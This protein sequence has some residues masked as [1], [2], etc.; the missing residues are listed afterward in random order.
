MLFLAGS[1]L[2]STS[3]TIGFK[4]CQGLRIDTFQAIIANYFVCIVTGFLFGSS[5]PF[6][7]NA[8]GSPWFPIAILLG[9][10]FITFFNLTAF[11]VKRLGVAVAGVATK[12]SLVIPFIFSL[13]YYGEHAG[14]QKWTGVAL[15]LFSVV[16][17][18]YD[19]RSNTLQK[20][21]L[22]LWILPF[23]LFL[24]TGFQDTMIKFAEHG[25]LMPAE[26]DAFLITC[27][28]VAFTIGL[29]LM[30]YLM[31]RRRLNFQ[32]KAMIAGICIGIPNY[33]SIWCLVKVLNLFPTESSLIIPVNN[34]AIVLLNAL[35]GYFL[36]KEKLSPTNV[37]GI[38]V[39]VLAIYLITVGG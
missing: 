32:A 33:F 16:L 23:L 10:C 18:C 19:P 24:G 31:A 5:H 12:I 7:A 11:T 30:I 8:G 13:F 2:F 25:Y 9:C 20:R 34:I 36:F 1:V 29:I 4:I 21:S 22:L 28:V 27:F 17:T 3:L 26:L 37:A 15:A 14:I 38:I 35:A 39:A 6:T